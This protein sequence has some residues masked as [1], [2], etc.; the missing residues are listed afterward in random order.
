MTRIDD[1]RRVDMEKRM[2]RLEGLNRWRS[3]TF[4]VLLFYGYLA[5]ILVVS[6]IAVYTVINSRQIA[7]EAH[8]GLCTLRAERF[9]RVN[10]TQQILNHS[11]DAYNANIIRTFGRELL[12]RSLETAKAD[13]KALEDVK[14]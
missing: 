3:S 9:A 10:A 2:T 11:E 13:A 5:A 14:C 8:R 12:V 4:G 6:A 7:V 1:N